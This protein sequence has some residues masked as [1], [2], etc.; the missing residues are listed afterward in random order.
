MT[1][2]IQ[3]ENG[4]NHLEIA[5]KLLKGTRPKPIGKTGF[6][7]RKV[8]SPSTNNGLSPITY[9]L[10]CPLG[11]VVG[12]YLDKTLLNIRARSLAAQ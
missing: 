4:S 9:R 11:R 2:L 8:V 5:Q 6:F 3:N 1:T 12:Y 7:S 10:I